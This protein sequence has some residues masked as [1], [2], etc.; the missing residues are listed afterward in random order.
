MTRSW[1]G[2]RGRKAI[3]TTVLTMLL[4]SSAAA[5]A[6]AGDDGEASFRSLYRELVEIDTTLSAGD[7]TAAS[8]AMAARLAAAGY[9]QADLQILGPAER[10]REHALIATLHGSAGSTLAPLLLLAHVDVVEARRADWQRDPFKL[11]E[12]DGWFYA[13]GASDDKAMAAIFTDAM[14]RYRREGYRPRRDIK[15]ALTCGEETSEQ[16]NSV[17]WLLAHQPDA[18]KAALALNEGAGGELDASGRPVS[19]QIQAG[20]KVY[21]DFTLEITNNGGH[22]SRPMADNAIYRLAAALQRL[23]AYTF[24]IALNDATRGYFQA[25]A[26]LVGGTTAADMLAVLNTPPNDAAAARLWAINPGWNSMLRTTC[27]ATQ[28]AAGHAPNALP[29][30]ATANVNCRILPGVSVDQVQQD[31]QRIVADDGIAIRRSEDPVT[32]AAPPLTPAILAPVR[33]VAAR[34]WPGV[35]VVPTM[36]T[37]A[38]D[39]RFLNAAGIPTYGLSGLFHDA[40][41]SRAHG[42]DE[43]IRVRSLM[44]GRRFLYDVVK[45]YGSA[46]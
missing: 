14:I 27:V 10:P 18:L 41:G 2:K 33:E 16:F 40:E 6:L 9:P 23:A 30:R 36:T 37:G 34:I 24:P 35:P 26:A 22:S 21:A 39:G 17:S 31:L 8:R 3:G 44:D 43:R 20:E 12:E 25:Q 28:L 19:L 13:R 29:Q 11:V 5:P 15:L 46:R 45:R 42:L 32:A 38:T 1:F 7:C 4:G